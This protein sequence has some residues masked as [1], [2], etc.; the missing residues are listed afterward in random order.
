MSVLKP[1]SGLLCPS[2]ILEPNPC[3]ARKDFAV[4]GLSSELH[5]VV[6]QIKMRREK[7]DPIK[8]NIRSA[9][10]IFR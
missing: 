7:R 8:H 4:N 3:R 10:K 5:P 2:K 1:S 9:T 6:A